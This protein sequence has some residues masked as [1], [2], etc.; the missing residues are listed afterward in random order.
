MIIKMNHVFFV[1]VLALT[2]IAAVA[3]SSTIT[4]TPGSSAAYVFCPKSKSAN[5]C[6]VSTVG[7]WMF[8]L[9]H[10]DD[11]ADSSKKPNSFR[12]TAGFVGASSLRLKWNDAAAPASTRVINRVFVGY[13]EFKADPSDPTKGTFSGI[14]D[15]PPKPSEG[16]CPSYVDSCTMGVPAGGL[17]TPLRKCNTTNKWNT[18]TGPTTQV[19]NTNWG[20]NTGIVECK[21]P[22]ESSFSNSYGNGVGNCV[23]HYVQRRSNN[24]SCSYGYNSTEYLYQARVYELQIKSVYDFT[25][26]TCTALTN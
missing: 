18:T 1:M 2:P 16:A 19:C 12:D 17:D 6:P 5:S 11:V 25:D 3:Q 23:A 8:K 14:V 20:P 10:E 4:V 26:A 21:M 7:R 15:I 24:F 13:G 22:L 9:Q